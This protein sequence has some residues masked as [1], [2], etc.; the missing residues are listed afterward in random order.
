MD[1]IDLAPEYSC[2]AIDRCCKAWYAAFQ[3]AQA[4]GTN[5][6]SV[7]LRANEAY[8][9]A[10]PP[11]NSVQNIKDFMACVVH[12]I[13]VGAIV[14]ERGNRWI[15]AARVAAEMYRKAPQNRGSS[16][17]KPR[18]IKEIRQSDADNISPCDTVQT[19]LST[20]PCEAY[21]QKPTPQEAHK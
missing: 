3:K 5:P 21:E 12:G 16:P 9:F 19:N 6:V 13:M 10:M 2:P 8:R 11:L 4:A 20:A 7:R 15:Q 17:R 14:D 1:N 18:K